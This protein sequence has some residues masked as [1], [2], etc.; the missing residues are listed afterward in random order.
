DDNTEVV[1]PKS[2]GTEVK[3]EVASGSEKWIW[4]EDSY[5]EVARS[6]LSPGEI[7]VI[8][9][10][11]DF[12]KFVSADGQGEIRWGA[13]KT[14]SFRLFVYKVSESE[15]IYSA[16]ADGHL[17]ISTGFE[18]VKKG[19]HYVNELSKVPEFRRMLNDKQKNY[20]P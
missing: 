19:Q 3:K 11:Y 17:W 16:Y 7:K 8:Q 15:S 18:D 6:K 20:Y 9:R 13:G 1:I 12:A 10:L 5:F 14:P 4:N 2:F